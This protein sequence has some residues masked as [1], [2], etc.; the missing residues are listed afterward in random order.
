MAS[1]EI[2]EV[3]PPTAE[4]IT[5]EEVRFHTRQNEGAT[6]P[7]MDD[8]AWMNGRIT[9]A[10][11][12]A[13]RFLGRF[14]TDATYEMA[15]DDFVAAGLL[16]DGAAEIVAVKYLDA[17]FVLQ[18]LDP[19]AYTF[20]DWTRM[21]YTADAWPTVSTRENSVRVTFKGAL[22]EATVQ[23]D[24]KTALLLMVGHLN[25]NREASL[26]GVSA[27]ELP[28]GVDTFLRPHRIR[29]GMA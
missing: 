11:Q 15:F 17:D 9:A 19:E 4:P 26:V 1:S 12:W 20:D 2:R 14:L 16:V 27:S 13:E 25:E 28:M 8:D 18:T 10:R 6:V 21:L 3:A 23:E 29:L 24:I 7:E 5:L 22:A